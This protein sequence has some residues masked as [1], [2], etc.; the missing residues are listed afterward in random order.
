MF[1]AA[2]RN[3]K[4][5]RTIEDDEAIGISKDMTGVLHMELP[6]EIMSST[7]GS[8]QANVRAD[9]EAKVKK[10][11]TGE[12]AG[13]ITPTTE[14][15]RGKTG[16]GKPSLLSSGGGP[17]VV[18]DPVIR[19]HES[20]VLISM[21]SEMLIVG[22]DGVGARAVADPKMNLVN[23][24]IGALLDV[25]YDAFN[26]KVLADV[27]RLNAVPQ[28]F[29]PLYDHGPVDGPDTGELIDMLVKLTGANIV[30]PSEELSRWAMTQIPGAP[31]ELTSAPIA[32][33]PEDDMT[34]TVEP[35]F[36]AD[37][38]A[39]LMS[40]GEVKAMLGLGTTGLR[41]LISEGKLAAYRVN[42]RWKFDPSAV[43]DLLT[44]SAH[45]VDAAPDGATLEE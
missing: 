34:M 20:R 6:L 38:L 8:A 7:A 24:M 25:F 31:T 5:A 43:R 3:W 19:R 14:D 2:V 15:A 30:L 26:T 36:S 44:A 9:W 16:Y 45:T 40:A 22:I 33:S 21:L 39:T 4:Y 29:W 13:L 35:K 41:K 28:Q 23:L 10:L 12:L 37:Q 11:Q 27:M 1:R 18:A 17:R 32:P 42:D